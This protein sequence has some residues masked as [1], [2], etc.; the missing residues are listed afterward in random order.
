MRC[1]DRTGTAPGPWQ[2]DFHARR[3]DTAGH[4][5]EVSSRKSL[6][7][8]RFCQQ[9][10]AAVTLNPLP[11]Y[12]SAGRYVLRLHRDAMQSAALA[13]RI[14]HVTSG[15]SIDFNSAAEL[16][17]WLHRHTQDLSATPAKDQP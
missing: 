2:D 15:D 4:E 3:A 7:W 5:P 12:P 6:R 10:G 13:G 14:E 9:G 1:R 8:G 16:V 17:A 11:V